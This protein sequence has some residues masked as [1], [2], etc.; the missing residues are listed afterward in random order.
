MSQLN[1]NSIHDCQ[2]VVQRFAS[3]ISHLYNHE[4]VLTPE[5][6][7]QFLEAASSD[8]VLN[9]IYTTSKWVEKIKSQP[10]SYMPSRKQI[11]RRIWDGIAWQK[12]TP[13]QRAAE[14]EKH[15][16]EREINGSVR[17]LRNGEGPRA[18]TQSTSRPVPPKPQFTQTQIDALREAFQYRA[19]DGTWTIT[20]EEA[21][22]MMAHH[23]AG[24]LLR[25]FSEVGE[26][27]KMQPVLPTQEEIFEKT[28]W[29]LEANVCQPVGAR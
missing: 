7:K 5:E 16:L 20:E 26:W 12:L 3:L 21:K 25:T 29:L 4:I 23:K 22:D 14:K 13:E 24:D 17:V 8:I 15:R 2:K 28:L 6:A 1:P 11:M 9:V 27:T 19:S 18:I 10:D